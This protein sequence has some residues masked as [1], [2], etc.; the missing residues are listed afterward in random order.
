MTSSGRLPTVARNRHSIHCPAP[1]LLWTTACPVHLCQ[2]L[3]ATVWTGLRLLSI[4]MWTVWQGCCT[5][6]HNH[7]GSV[8]VLVLQDRVLECIVPKQ[9]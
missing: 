8:S 2:T 7:V 9:K 4:Q 5:S 1:L 6:F 3:F